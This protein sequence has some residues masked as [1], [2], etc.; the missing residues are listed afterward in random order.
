MWLKFHY[1]RRMPN[2]GVAP[3]CKAGLQQMQ[4]GGYQTEKV[5]R[6]LWLRWKDKVAALLFQS[7]L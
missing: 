5:A 2:S 6:Q 7:A 1:K 3:I 4:A